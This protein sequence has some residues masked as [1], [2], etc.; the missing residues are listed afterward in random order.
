MQFQEKSGEIITALITQAAIRA[1]LF[2]FLMLKQCQIKA[3]LYSS[4]C[5]VLPI[6]YYILAT[7]IDLISVK[8]MIEDA[9]VLITDF[10][11]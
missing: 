9:T 7:H 3:Y 10:D 8:E 2:S 1:A 5:T 11:Y 4:T 6:M